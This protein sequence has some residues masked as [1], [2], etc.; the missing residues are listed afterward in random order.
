M[1]TSAAGQLRASQ[2]VDPLQTVRFALPKSII[3]RLGRDLV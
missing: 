1:L 3:S 2:V